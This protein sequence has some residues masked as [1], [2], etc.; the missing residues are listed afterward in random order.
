MDDYFQGINEGNFSFSFF[1]KE[2]GS[3]LKIDLL[4]FDETILATIEVSK[5]SDNYKDFEITVKIS[6]YF[7]S[8]AVFPENCL[9]NL[10]VEW[11][12]G[13]WAFEAHEKESN[14]YGSYI[15]GIAFKTKTKEILSQ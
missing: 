4:L 10:V 5:L 3:D 12:D 13:S 14:K 7:E 15:K 2:T 9:Q 1:A 11:N 6:D 8:I